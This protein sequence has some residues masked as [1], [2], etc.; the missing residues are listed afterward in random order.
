MHYLYFRNTLPFI[1]QRH[2]A[3][4]INKKFKQQSMSMSMSVQ[5]LTLSQIQFRQ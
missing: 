2:L 3:N 4:V 5:N 1:R